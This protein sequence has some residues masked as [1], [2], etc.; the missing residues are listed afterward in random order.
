MQATRMCRRS[1]RPESFGTAMFKHKIKFELTDIFQIWQQIVNRHIFTRFFAK[2]NYI[3]LLSNHFYDK[4][5]HHLNLSRELGIIHCY[6]CFR[7]QTFRVQN[8]ASCNCKPATATL[9]SMIGHGPRQAMSSV[10]SSVTLCSVAKRYSKSV[11]KL[12]GAPP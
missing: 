5:K 6:I 1:N 8:A 9:R 11:N 7:V 10:C 3:Q 12:I 2:Q 4:M